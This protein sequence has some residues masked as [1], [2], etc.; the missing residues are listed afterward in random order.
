MPFCEYQ[1]C[2]PQTKFFDRFSPNSQGMFG[3]RGFQVDYV[4]EHLDQV[5]LL[6]VNS[7]L[8]LFVEPFFSAGFWLKLIPFMNSAPG[9]LVKTLTMAMVLKLYGLYLFLFL[10]TF[11]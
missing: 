1:P 10:L 9:H 3:T 7:N 4:S 6:F 11:Y 2:V 8:F 5:N